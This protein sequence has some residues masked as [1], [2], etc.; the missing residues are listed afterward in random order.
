M[1]LGLSRAHF[2]SETG[3]CR[4][5]DASA[6]GYCRSEGCG[7]FVL[8]RLDDAL[9]ENDR[10]LGVI[11]GVEVN[12][13]GN[14]DSITHPHVPTQIALFE[15]LLARSGVHP[16]NI[17]VVECHGTGTQAGDPAELEA[18]RAV[19][20]VG[21]APDNPLHITS[22]KASIGHAEAASGAASLAKLILMLRE[23]AIPR[24]PSF[25]QLNP[26]IP[27]LAI[28]NVQIDTDNVPWNWDGTRMA[29]LN[30]FGASGSNAALILEEYTAPPRSGCAS[31]RTA[32]V[33]GIA[34][35]SVDAAEKLRSAYV[36]QLEASHG[37]PAALCDFAYSATAR[38]QLHPFRLSAAGSSK[39]EIVQR[40]RCA[41]ITE[42]QPADRVVFVFSGQGLQYPGMGA[43]LYRQ[44]PFVSKIV[45]ECD[46]KLTNWGF[47]T[48]LNV[49]RERSSTEPH[50][51][52]PSLQALQ[53]ALFVLEYTLAQ[54]WISWGVRPCAIVGHWY[55]L[56]FPAP[57]V[58]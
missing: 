27:D 39:D 18:I 53:T 30:N 17:S 35:K 14:A 24:H 54:L 45:D 5:W 56:C 31:F 6:D 16:H 13:S 38:R 26:R 55:V 2:L 15:N 9:A 41:S 36:A 33:V 25:V 19:F 21:R 48:I 10:I 44:L 28:D 29:L 50:C 43:E 7:L 49:F 4:P 40:L 8:K 1:Y 23:K 12:Q 42:V 46:Q 20:A 34:C 57:T 11:R 52:S 22:V 51:D 3:Q 58:D 37:D 47:D 32:L